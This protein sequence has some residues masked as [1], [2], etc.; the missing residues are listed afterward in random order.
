MISKYYN[1]ESLTFSRKKHV[2]RLPLI[3]STN[4]ACKSVDGGSP[5]PDA[6]VTPHGSTASDSHGRRLFRPLDMAGASKN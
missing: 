3:S 5:E 6:G 2:T 4:D 1:L